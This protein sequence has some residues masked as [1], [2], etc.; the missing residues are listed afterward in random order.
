MNSLMWKLAGIGGAAVAG[1]VTR[2]V[3]T[4]AWQK[5]TGKNPPDDVEDPDIALV[6][7]IG[8]SVLSGVGVAVVQLLVKRTIA[9]QMH[10]RTAAVPES[11]ASE[12]D[13]K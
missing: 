10:A 1:M 5:S 11:I 8:W 3:M 6:E 12:L 9:Q 2:K 4:T 13:D 7:A